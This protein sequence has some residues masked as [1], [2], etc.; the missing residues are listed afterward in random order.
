M[1][2][3]DVMIQFL[4]CYQMIDKLSYNIAMISDFG[5]PFVENFYS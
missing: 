1:G 5:E 2:F 3:L 4:S